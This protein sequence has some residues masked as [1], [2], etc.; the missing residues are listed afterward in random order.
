R[1]VDDAGRAAVLAALVEWHARGAG[2]P[3]RSGHTP[4]ANRRTSARD[5]L[6]R[7]AGLLADG[8]FDAR[9]AKALDVALARADAPLRGELRTLAAFAVVMLTDLRGPRPRALAQALAA[10]LEAWDPVRGSG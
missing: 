4:A 8:A 3:R 10:W 5:P 1:A 9:A 2:G 7:L 6:A